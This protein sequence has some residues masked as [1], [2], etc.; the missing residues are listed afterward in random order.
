MKKTEKQH[1]RI[2]RRPGEKQGMVAHTC[3][4]STWEAETKGMLVQGQPGLH[5]ETLSQKDQR[6]L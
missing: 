1:P 4:P 5:S 3:G 2:K 6:S